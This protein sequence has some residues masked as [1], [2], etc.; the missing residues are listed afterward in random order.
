MGRLT[1]T[2][3]AH[4][5]LRRRWPVLLALV[6]PVLAAVVMGLSGWRAALKALP[7]DGIGLAAAV[8]FLLGA[9]S[10]HAL[11]KTSRRSAEPVTRL[12]DAM[13]LLESGALAHRMREDGP[14]SLRLA[15]RDFNRMAETIEASVREAEVRA[16]RDALT[17]L[18][19]HREFHRLLDE[20]L[21][22]CRRYGRA[23]TV[24]MIDLDDFKLVNDRHGHRVGDWALRMFATML[25]HT[26]RQTDIVARP[27]GDEFA[28]I[29]PETTIVGGQRTAARILQAVADHPFW[30]PQGIRILLSFS[31]GLAS[32][33][34][35]GVAAGDLMD[36]ADRRLYQAK[37]D[38]T[39]YEPKL[40]RIG[41]DGQDAWPQP[42]APALPAAAGHDPAP[43]ASRGRTAIHLLAVRTETSLPCVC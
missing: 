11:L 3:R 18:Y 2:H 17:D 32:Y 19:N 35:D 27:G 9:S 25:R 39:G 28:V 30:V 29:L 20:E 1:S 14:E 12:R 34:E 40:D 4:A 16:S 21:A 26:V 5:F 24:M 42:E 6:L 37:R 13:L 10:A 36:A 38:R 31:A 22:R 23:M 7:Y 41:F 15:A 33:P 43:Q 8:A